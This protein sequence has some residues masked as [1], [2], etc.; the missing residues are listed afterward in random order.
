MLKVKQL[1]LFIYAFYIIYLP[2]IQ[3][4]NPM[5]KQSLFIVIFA[6]INLLFL[7]KH[8]ISFLNKAKHFKLIIIY[9][10]LFMYI[11][12]LNISNTNIRFSFIELWPILQS[13]IQI[14]NYIALVIWFFKLNKNQLNNFYNFLLAVGLFQSF[15]IFLMVLIPPF[16]E[17]ANLLYTQG[18]E[19]P[20]FISNILSERIFG[21]A[22]DYT[23]V[24]PF[25]QVLFAILSLYLF[26]KNNNIKYFIISL[27][28]AI[29][30]IL[31]GRTA[32]YVYIFIFGIYLIYFLANKISLKRIIILVS[33]A[34]II[35]LALVIMSNLLPNRF[36]A[37]SSGIEDIF[38]F[39]KTGETRD[40]IAN[41]TSDTVIIP[42]VFTIIF[43]TGHRVFGKNG[44]EKFGFATDIG[45][46]NDIYQG[47]LIYISL[48]YSTIIKFMLK[49]RDDLFFTLTLLLC[50][51]AANYKATIL[52]ST[53]VYILYLLCFAKSYLKELESGK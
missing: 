49:N 50:L 3:F 4:I 5:L 23:V 31:N 20:A 7:N 45:Y 16:K 11:L 41:L 24:L 30:S 40:D 2:S 32:F 19:L 48:L 26:S 52:H 6:F 43:G 17:V 33:T 13:I 44:L 29:S 46:Y 21:V 8:I 27:I 1:L 9:I 25:V 47:G 38:V 51:S 10:L 12:F 37:I 34:I 28:L 39:I 36:L 22:S 15:L 18:E 35:F 53:I 42:S 14:I